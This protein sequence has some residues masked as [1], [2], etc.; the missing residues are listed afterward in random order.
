MLNRRQLLQVSVLATSQAALAAGGPARNAG[1][2][3]ARANLAKETVLP[4]RVYVGGYTSDLGWI[5]GR[6]RGVAVYRLDPV[7]GQLK[8]LSEVACDNPSYLARHP[9]G[10]F[11][12]AT[13]ENTRF[14]NPPDHS[15]SAFSVAEDGSLTL[16]NRVPSLGGAPCH[17]CVEPTGRFV[18]SANYSG[19]NF[20]VHPVNADG[21]L[22][23]ASDNTAQSRS[24]DGAVRPQGRHAHSINISPGGTFAL[25]CDL[26]LDRVLVYRLDLAGGRLVPHGEARVA[27]G[28]GPRH[29]DFHPS[30]R[31]A[32]VI[33]ELAGTMSVFAWDAANGTLAGLQ[34]VSALADDY[35]GRK[36][37]ADVHVHPSGRFVYGSNRSHD[38]I[39]IFAVNPSTGRLSLVGHEA[40]RGRTPR[41]FALS[42][43]G[44]LLL[45][46]NQDS[47]SIAVFRIDPTS[48][49]LRHLATSDI[50]TPVCIKFA[51]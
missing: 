40:T 37:S 9:S 30:G 39:V 19:G 18:L 36:W 20:V 24:G 44:D 41:N 4:S 17:L 1:A 26:G 8:L 32:Y 50:P 11:L 46:A 10:R 13:N 7:S 21:S 42:P 12:Y 15:I 33:N 25:G 29:L 28:S 43:A 35:T 3:S 38:S 22:A 27:A 23:Q 16:L 31:F 34:T 51:G 5:K 45:A 48:G 14:G 2:D 47:S 49:K 6:A